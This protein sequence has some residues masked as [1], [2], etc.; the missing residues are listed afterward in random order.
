M[1]D[2]G[3]V[4][5]R[6]EQR[7]AAGLAQARLFDEQRTGLTRVAFLLTG[8]RPVA[9]ELVQDAFG[10]TPGSRTGWVW[11]HATVVASKS[12]GLR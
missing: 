4:D 9:E 5:E 11:D 6:A 12:T 2:D 8:S 1:V 7:G 3:L 10:V